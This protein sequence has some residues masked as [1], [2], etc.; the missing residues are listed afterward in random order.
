MLSFFVRNCLSHLFSASHTP[1]FFSAE[2]QNPFSERVIPSKN[3]SGVLYWKSRCSLPCDVPGVF[4]SYPANHRKDIPKPGRQSQDRSGKRNLAARDPCGACGSKGTAWLGIGHFPLG[5]YYMAAERKVITPKK[6][7]K[8]SRE[9][10]V[11]IAR[12]RFFVNLG[13]V[14][15][16]RPLFL[17]FFSL[18]LFFSFFFSK[19]TVDKRYPIGNYSY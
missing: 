19:K 13:M 4:R 6:E 8:F 7:E 17:L 10:G 3:S 11:G 1:R 2:A 15:R 5:D 18:T 16:D 9:E 12:R 14:R